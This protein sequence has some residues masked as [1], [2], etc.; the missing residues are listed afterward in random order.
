MSRPGFDITPAGLQDPAP[1]LPAAPQPA[2]ARWRSLALPR[3]A[4]KEQE[5][6]NGNLE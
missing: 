3:R 1:V 2:P 5:D 4:G 6:I